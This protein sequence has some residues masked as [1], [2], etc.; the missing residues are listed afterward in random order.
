MELTANHIWKIKFEESKG[1]RGLNVNQ[2]VVIENDLR[3]GG[4]ISGLPTR[5]ELEAAVRENNQSGSST[6]R[7]NRFQEGAT[8]ENIKGIFEKSHHH[9]R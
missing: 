9:G 1:V 3:S 6:S 8:V 4:V 7:I 5:S 2:L